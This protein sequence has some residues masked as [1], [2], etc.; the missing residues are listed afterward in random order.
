V[1]ECSIPEGETGYCGVRTNRGDRI[2]GVIAEE[3]KLSWYH[4]PLPTNCVGD[5]VCPG[6]IGAGY[7]TYAYR[8]GPET[9]YKNPFRNLVDYYLGKALP[10]LRAR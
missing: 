1:N 3:G 8:N 9:G 2:T 7:P 5:W 10:Q 4:D 6:G